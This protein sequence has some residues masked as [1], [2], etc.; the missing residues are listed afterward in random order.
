MQIKV[1]GSGCANCKKLEANV[2]E[3]V[4]QINVDADIQKI[5]DIQEIMGYGVLSTPG[6]VV[7]GELKVSGRVPNVAEIINILRG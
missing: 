6:L 3:A 7:D 4:A 5:E 2:F 1:L